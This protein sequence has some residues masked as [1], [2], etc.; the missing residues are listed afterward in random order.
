MI[1]LIYIFYCSSRNIVIEVILSGFLDFFLLFARKDS[2]IDYVRIGIDRYA[3]IVG[4]LKVTI[5]N[6]M[7]MDPRHY[8]RG[9]KMAGQCCTIVA[10]FIN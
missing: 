6:G 7:E 3:S 1:A 5:G 9:H 10:R 2:R 4:L 8:M